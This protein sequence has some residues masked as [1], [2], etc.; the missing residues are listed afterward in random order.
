VRS[1]A[2]ALVDLCCF[3]TAPEPSHQ[4]VR[5][6]VPSKYYA[7]AR[8]VHIKA[9]SDL[10][11]GPGVRGPVA[12][13]AVPESQYSSDYGWL[14]SLKSTK[15]VPYCCVLVWAGGYYYERQFL[16][17]HVYRPTYELP[18]PDLQSAHNVT[19]RPARAPRDVESLIRYDVEQ[20]AFPSNRLGHPILLR[21]RNHSYPG[22][23]GILD[24]PSWNLPVLEWAR[25]QGGV[26]GYAHVGHSLVVN[27]SQLPNYE[28][29]PLDG[30]GANECLVDVAH[31]YV[32]FLAG[33]ESRP[34]ADLN[35]WYHL[36]SCGFPIPMIGETDFPVGAGTR[37]MG[38]VRTYVKLDNPPR[39]D[40]GYDA[41]VAGIQAGRLYFGD[42]RSHLLDVRANEVRAG[43]GPLAMSRP[44]RINLSI[45]VAALLDENPVNP[46]E[47][48][49][50]QGFA[51]WHIER[52]RIGPS[53]RVPLEVVVNGYVV[54]RRELTADGRVLNLS[55]PVQ[56][57]H[58]SWIAIRILPSVHSA[59]IF[60]IVGGKPVR[61]SR[62]SANWCLACVDVLWR[63]H[64]SRIRESERAAAAEAWESARR[65][66]RD[67]A[68]ES[69]SD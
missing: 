6:N 39:D 4:F 15:S 16:T 37:V 54:E 5:L 35:V 60:V 34:V 23:H 53:R 10:N 18:F 14:I 12:E 55:I 8:N 24:W 17:G 57:R 56:I 68:I 67:I 28:I 41:W 30:L 11:V 9:I 1:F 40:A 25:R 66:Y 38:T 51:Y 7:Y 47:D 69:V 48:P 13:V 62:R 29:P 63:K 65:V 33:G 3:L 32:D 58:S 22:G 43:E 20:A 44:G 49:D 36:L 21:I 52:G 45:S 27:S 31:G 42:G 59:P 64:S 46:D 50:V 19:L 61:A 2:R 26:S